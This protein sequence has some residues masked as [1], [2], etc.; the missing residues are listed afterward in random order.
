MTDDNKNIDEVKCPYCA[1]IIKAK[2]KKCK[3]CGETIEAQIKED[4]TD[5]K[6]N[7]K[8]IIF[9]VLIS[10]IVTLLLSLA[11]ENSS[12]VSPTEVEE[13]SNIAP[14]CDSDWAKEFVKNTVEDGPYKNS[15]SVQLLD[16]GKTFEIY[17]DEKN[18][19]RECI[20][21]VVLNT[22][23]TSIF[24]KFFPT[25]DGT[26]FLISYQELQADFFS[27]N[28]EQSPKQEDMKEVEGEWEAEELFLQELVNGNYQKTS[29][30]KNTIT[31]HSNY[32]VYKNSLR[33][34]LV[35]TCKI[36]RYK[37]MLETSYCH[38]S[39]Q[40]FNLTCN[41]YAGCP[42]LATDTFKLTDQGLEMNTVVSSSG[43]TEN[44][45][46]K[47]PDYI[48][49]I[50]Q[51]EERQRLELERLQNYNKPLTNDSQIETPPVQEKTL[52]K[53]PEQEVKKD[54]QDCQPYTTPDG[55]QSGTACK[56]PNGTWKIKTI[57]SI[58]A[59]GQ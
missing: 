48:Q 1:E 17:N 33:N 6:L 7:K 44:I 47:R 49:K 52:D 50:K 34:E 23:T 59:N 4:E 21:N 31:I 28:P 35:I 16:F 20:A 26:S 46:F 45:I 14:M 54:S 43:R 18:N 30:G 2:A 53:Q 19:I 8:Y 57:D 24:Y 58:K 22:G 41:S 42:A 9:V 51:E 11:I 36:I 27:I 13:T 3:H 15:V 37:P 10:I 55:T 5:I 38:Y 12:G 32:A 29:L 40:D 39:N 56:L 25:S